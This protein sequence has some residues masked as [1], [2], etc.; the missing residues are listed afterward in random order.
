MPRLAPRAVVVGR[1]SRYEFFK[2]SADLSIRCVVKAPERGRFRLRPEF[3]RL[4]ESAADYSSAGWSPPEPASASSAGLHSE[5]TSR[6]CKPPPSQGWGI[7]NR[8]NEDFSTGLDIQAI[9]G[10][11]TRGRS[12]RTEAART[13][14][15]APGCPRSVCGYGSP[16]AANGASRTPRSTSRSRPQSCNGI[17]VVRVFL[18]PGAIG[19]S[20]DWRIS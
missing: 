16:A 9:S 17:S 4:D 20:S 18:Q 5:S 3:H 15:P 1:S 6:N 11:S 8:R 12:S 2:A 14:R 10:S 7:F 19:L 13:P